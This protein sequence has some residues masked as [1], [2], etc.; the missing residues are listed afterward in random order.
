MKSVIVDI[1]DVR[2][3]LL[4][5]F[6]VAITYGKVSL[7]LW[8]LGVIVLV[9]RLWSAWEFCCVSW[10]LLSRHYHGHCFKVHRCWWMKTAFGVRRYVDVGKGLPG[11]LSL[12]RRRQLN[13]FVCEIKKCSATFVL[14]LW[15]VTYTV[16]EHTWLKTT[17]LVALISSCSAS[18]VMLWQV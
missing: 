12:C 1:V 15:F 14:Y 9:L 4:Q 17:S 7:W 8:K 5:S 18:I 11:G 6:F 10:C 13:C 16:L 3:S 2:W